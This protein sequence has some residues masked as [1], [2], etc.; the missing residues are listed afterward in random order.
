M[1]KEQGGL[2]VGFSLPRDAPWTTPLGRGAALSVGKF[3]VKDSVGILNKGS[4]RAV[5]GDFC[6]GYNAQ[7]CFGWVQE[8]GFSA[9]ETLNPRRLNPK[10]LNP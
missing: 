3:G 9:H 5:R 6:T 4:V 1:R 2:G 8:L 7:L 10:P